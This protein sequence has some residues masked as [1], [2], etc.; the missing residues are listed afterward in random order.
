MFLSLKEIKKEKFRYGLIIGMIVLIGYLI[1]ILTSLAMGLA[2]QNTDAINSW[3]INSVALNKDANTSLTQSLITND[4][5]KNAKLTKNEAYI[6][7]ASVVVKKSGLTK[8]SA[9]FLGLKPNQ[10][11]AQNLKLS[12][13]HKIQKTN[14]V[15]VDEQFK[16]D[17]YQLGDKIKF[18]SESQ[19]YTIVGFIKNAKLNIAPVVYGNISNWKNIK[20]LNGPFAAS[21]IVSKNA[22]FSMKDDQVKTYSIST[23]ISKLPGYSAQNSTF[24]FMIA[25]LMIIS[26]I[27]IA[28]FL[29]ILTIQKIQNY[30]VLRAQGIPAKTLV[31]ATISQSVILVVSGLFIATILTG[32]T[33]FAMPNA[34]PMSFNIPI[35]SAVGLGLILTGLLGS[36][37]PIKI[38]LNVDPVSVIGG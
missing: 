13:G 35:L 36:L 38:I 17:G 3:N 14:Q 33:A 4:N 24:T 1:F 11:I 28:V 21:A 7:Q 29:Y 8:E 26:L 2:N 37:I 10:F 30:A 32:I 16:N 18:N 15:V 22:K 34:V 19:N 20:N 25:F 9:Q 6:G 31:N 27:V 23:F 12:S 5:A